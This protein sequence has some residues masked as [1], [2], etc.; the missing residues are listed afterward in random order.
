MYFGRH[1]AFFVLFL[2][3][4]YILTLYWLCSG[5]ASGEVD[6]S[7]WVVFLQGATGTSSQFL[8]RWFRLA[9]LLVSSKIY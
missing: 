8:A 5:A 7:S 3:F 1:S 4:S 2:Y 9:V 6:L